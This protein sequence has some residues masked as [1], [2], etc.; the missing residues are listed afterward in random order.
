MNRIK[1]IIIEDEPLPQK[2]LRT[3]VDKNQE[4]NLIGVFDDPI[5]AI[6]I[7]SSGQVQLIFQIFKCQ[8]WMVFLS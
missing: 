8:N 6:E 5:E 4:L 7:M 1:T 2:R 3:M